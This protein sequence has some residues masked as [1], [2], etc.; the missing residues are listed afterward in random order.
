[1]TEDTAR[2]LESAPA[3]DYEAKSVQLSSF[4]EDSSKKNIM[5]SAEQSIEGA[6]EEVASDRK[7]QIQSE[8]DIA[9]P[10]RDP[11]RA[12]TTKQTRGAGKSKV[13]SNASSAKKNEILEIVQNKQDRRGKGVIFS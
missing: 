13:V 6:A 4:G 7:S 5:V 8:G 2:N 1:M 3:N 9:T 11:K 12:P 10:D